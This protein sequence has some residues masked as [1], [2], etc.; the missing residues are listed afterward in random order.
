MNLFAGLSEGHAIPQSSH[1]RRIDIFSIETMNRIH[2]RYW[3]AA[4]ASFYSGIHPPA[5]LQKSG[6]STGCVCL[7][8]RPGCS[9]LINLREIARVWAGWVSVRFRLSREPQ[10]S[11]ADLA[12][13]SLA[14]VSIGE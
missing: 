5:L 9:V 12:K 7:E 1:S 3:K 14:R 6:E 13:P 4:R 10:S 8:H 2:P 11:K